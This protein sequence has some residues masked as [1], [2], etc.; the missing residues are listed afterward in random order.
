MTTQKNLPAPD[1]ASSIAEMIDALERIRDYGGRFGEDD[2]SSIATDI[3]EK[4]SNADGGMESPTDS[5]AG[6][7]ESWETEMSKVMPKDFKDFWDNSKTEWP[8]VTRLM[9][10]SLKN[11]TNDLTSYEDDPQSAADELM[12]NHDVFVADHKDKALA[13]LSKREMIRL[14]TLAGRPPLKSEDRR[15]ELMATRLAWLADK[16][17]LVIDWDD[18]RNND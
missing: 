2:P 11:D 3:L 13:G 17:T 9:I 15:R 8:L 12:A 7:L 18:R 16:V 14:L 6:R 1:G 4:I 10:E 5:V